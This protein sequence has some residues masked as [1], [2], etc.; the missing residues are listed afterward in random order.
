LRAIPGLNITQFGA[1]DIN[2]NSR[3]ST[4]ILANSM[5]VMVDGRS[6]FQPLYGAVYWD[7]GTVAKDEIDQI[8]VLRSPNSALWGANALSGVINVRTKSPRQIAG[9]RGE[10]SFGERGTKSVNGTWAAATDSISYKLAGSYFEQDAWDRPTLLPNGNPMPATA[11]FTNRGTSQPKIDVR[12]DWDRDRNRVWSLRGGLAGANGLI[13]T[14]IGP[15]DLDAG[16]YASYLEVQRSS[17]EMDLRVYWNRLDAPF[18]FVLF[19]LDEDAVNDT[20]VGEVTRRVTIGSRHRLTFG[21]TIRADKFDLTIAPHENGRVDG[22]AFLEDKVTVNRVL[23][24]VAGGRVDKFDT[25]NAVFAP[26]LGV[27]VTPAPAHAFRVTYNRAYRAPSLIENFANIALPA[28]LPDPPFE[29]SQLALGSTEL[30]ME[31][32]DAVEIGYTAVIGSR[33]TVFATVYDQ[34]ISNNILFLPV[35]FYGPHNPPPEWPGDPQSVPLLPALFSFVN[36]SEVRDRGIELATRVEWPGVSLQASYTYQHDP[37]LNSG[38]DVPLAINRPARNQASGGLT[39]VTNHWTAAGDVQFTDR[40][41][42]ADVLTPE[43]WGYTDSF[44]TV[45]A[46]AIYRPRGPSWEFWLSGTNLLD[47]PVQSHVFGDI[48]RRKLTAGMR[49]HWEP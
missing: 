40:A 43:F 3:S 4:G 18:R 39:Y 44:F 5:L 11:L 49:W 37:S 14:G 29:Y 27:V 28:F 31:K 16:A 34:R 2:V 17:D 12:I 45:N 8:E 20:F 38:A 6:F 25:T 21:G 15:A 41:F 7:L 36:L 19:G 42:W 30:E 48:V 22:A 33:A 46:R 35:A 10:V 9:F 23:T 32:Q 47:R 13:H 26:R 24:V 1:R